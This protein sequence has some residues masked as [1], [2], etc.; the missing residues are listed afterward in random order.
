MR[1][2]LVVLAALV[3]VPAA[4]AH[5]EVTPTSIEVDHPTLLTLH[6]PCESATAAIV[7]VQV[8]ATG[9]EL[10]GSTTW[11][12]RSRGVVRFGFTARAEK[13]GDYP[14]HVRQVYSDGEVVQWAG[15]ASSN[16]PAPVVRAEAKENENRDRLLIAIVVAII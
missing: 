6:V 9:L 8:T 2:A 12:G 1:V 11:T 15:P 5:A 14:L 10:S 4:Y 13:V 7:A 16:A 3:V